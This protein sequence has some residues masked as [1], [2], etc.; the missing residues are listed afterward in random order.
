MNN[1]AAYAVAARDVARARIM[2]DDLLG[3]SA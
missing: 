3:E 1:A 2:L